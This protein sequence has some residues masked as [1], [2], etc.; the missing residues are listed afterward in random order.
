M[1]LWGPVNGVFTASA[2]WLPNLD[3]LDK[4]QWFPFIL[5]AT[6]AL[7]TALIGA[8]RGALAAQKIAKNHKQHEEL[9][10][11]IRACNAGITISTFMLDYAVGVYEVAH[12][13]RENYLESMRLHNLGTPV[14]TPQEVR[15]ISASTPPIVELRKIIFEDVTAPVSALRAIMSLSQAVEHAVNAIESRNELLEKFRSNQYPD[16]FGFTEMYYGI[17]VGGVA[18]RDYHDIVMNLA[19]TSDEMLFFS[20]VLCVELYEHASALRKSL[21]TFSK[22]PVVVRKLLLRPDAEARQVRVREKYKDWY[23]SMKPIQDMRRK[24]WQFWR[25]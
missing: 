13:M 24:W 20:E 23:A 4:F 11:E 17:P 3:F 7:I 10:K 18:H 15:G 2:S 19:E 6:A 16:G 21:K 25:K 5:T 14:I 1:T 9:I 22:E 8:R 12:P